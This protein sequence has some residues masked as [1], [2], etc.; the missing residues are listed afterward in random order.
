MKLY[1]IEGKFHLIGPDNEF[2]GTLGKVFG[3]HYTTSLLKQHFWNARNGI[4]TTITD[5]SNLDERALNA[6]LALKYNAIVKKYPINKSDSVAQKTEQSLKIATEYANLLKTFSYS[7]HPISEEEVTLYIKGDQTLKVLPKGVLENG[8]VGEHLVFCMVTASKVPVYINHNLQ[9][10]KNWPT[11]EGVFKQ[12]MEMTQE[13][14]I[15][16][17]FLSKQPLYYS[18]DED[19]D[20]SIWD[21][22]NAI[23]M[24]EL[25]ACL[26]EFE[27]LTALNQK[28]TLIQFQN[29]LSHSNEHSGSNTTS[30]PK[31][32]V[33]I[34]VLTGNLA[35]NFDEEL[36]DIATQTTAPIPT[37]TPAQNQI[38]CITPQFSSTKTSAIDS[39]SIHTQLKDTSAPS[40]HNSV[41]NKP[42][43]LNEKQVL[44]LEKILT[45]QALE[46]SKKE[47]ESKKKQM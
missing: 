15:I 43:K 28:P 25:L 46:K 24:M 33:L 16:Y 41:T 42:P 18:F 6:E 38:A 32:D 7:N 36:P 14:S 44:E 37:P 1:Y 30:E 2:D 9:W 39:N 26:Y 17:Q 13:T 19:G 35:D 29:L 40:T 8:S 3:H 22:P 12:L 20:S 34:T 45:A 11:R 4:Q 27:T 21:D 23:S 5:L 31:S 47:T 10:C